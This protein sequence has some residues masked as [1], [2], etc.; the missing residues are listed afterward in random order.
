MISPKRILLYSHDTFGLGHIRRT[1]KIANAIANP[2]LTILVA[3]ASPKTS[4]FSSL[5]GIEYLNLPGFAKQLSGEYLPRSLNIP[6][7]QFVN[8]RASLLLSA[9][10]SFSPD[11]V[12]VDKEPLGV[13]GEL[14]PSLEYLRQHAKQC[15]TICGFRDILDETPTVHQEWHEKGTLAGL[16][17]F[18][19]DIFIYGD[20]ELYDF[21]AEYSL[22]KDLA[23]HLTY[24]GY[25]NAECNFDNE[26]LPFHF[27][28]GRPVVT[29]T[30]GGG[31]DG[32]ELMEDYLDAL[33]RAPEP[34]AFHNIVLTGPFAPPT[35]LKKAKTLSEQRGGLE[36]ANFISNTSGLFARSAAVVS[37]G[38][39]NTL[40]ELAAQRKY[41]LVVPRVTPRKEQLLRAIAFKRRGYCDYLEPSTA[42]GQTLLEAVG[43]HLENR[44]ASIPQFPT[45]G[46]DNI[47]RLVTQI[48]ACPKP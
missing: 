4:S 3:C 18:Y 36:A 29:F 45:P 47:K 20:R 2:E 5:P 40:C 46:L 39:Y 26:E 33:A 44:P 48:L 9:V 6:G 12:I 1:Q 28:G 22:P 10:R 13:R 14:L 8:L 21:V 16:R 37:M 42:N 15:R 38:G 32:W 31:S 43:R 7:A 17:N 27:D 41:P 30:L 34:L 19:D 24:T 11:I 25:L 23:A 35:L